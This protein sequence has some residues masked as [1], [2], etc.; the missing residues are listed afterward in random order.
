[1]ARTRHKP[2]KPGG[3]HKAL[4][5]AVGRASRNSAKRGSGVILL[6]TA[7]SMGMATRPNYGDLVSTFVWVCFN[8]AADD[9]DKS[10]CDVAGSIHDIAHGIRSPARTPSAVANASSVFREGETLPR[11]TR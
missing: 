4:R 1:M 7:G 10:S 8:D 5:S 9:S 11:S 6:I 3:L 2:P